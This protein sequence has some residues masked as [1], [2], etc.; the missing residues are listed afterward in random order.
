MLYAENMRKAIGKEPMI[1]KKGRTEL[2]IKSLKRF[3]VNKELEK[4]RKEK[5]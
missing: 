1:F 2:I 4:F 3:D 5:K